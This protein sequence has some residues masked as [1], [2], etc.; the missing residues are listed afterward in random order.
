MTIELLPE[1][2]DYEFI[3]TVDNRLSE[4]P[5]ST[6]T[7]EDVI[8]HYANNLLYPMA[9]MNSINIIWHS[10]DSQEAESFKDWKEKAQE[11]LDTVQNLLKI[12]RGEKK[13]QIL[14]QVKQANLNLAFKM[15]QRIRKTVIPN[16]KETEEI[17]LF[18]LD[19]TPEKEWLPY[20]SVDE[21]CTLNKSR[22]EQ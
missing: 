15:H 16:L 17:L 21:S 8:K 5:D 14:R 10:T 7:H 6:S 4:W 11:L 3:F 9:R 2:Q 22:R 18:I 19:K 1:I 12:F 13:F 20:F